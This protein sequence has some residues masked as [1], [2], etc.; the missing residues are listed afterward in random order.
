MIRLKSLLLEKKDKSALQVLFVGD[1]QTLQSNSYAKQLLKK[2]N[3]EGKI[4][5]K[6]NASLSD[7]FIMLQDNMSEQYDVVSILCGDDDSKKEKYEPSIEQLKQ[8]YLF[9]KK[10]DC[11]LVTITTPTKQYSKDPDKYP[12]A[13]A[14]SSWI[15]NQTISDITINLTGLD[16]LDFKKNGILLDSDTNKRVAAEWYSNVVNITS[17]DIESDESEDDTKKIIFSINSEGPDV[18][19]LQINLAALGYLSTTYKRTGNYDD[20]TKSA[21]QQFQRDNGLPDNGEYTVD[22]KDILNK[23]L[24][25]SN[26]DDN[27]KLANLIP[28]PKKHKKINGEIATATDIIDFFKDKGL[29]TEGAAGIA[30]NIS[31]ET[32]GTFSTSILGDN[33]TSIGLAQ[34]HNE[35]WTGPNGFEQWCTRNSLDPWSVE[36]Q[37]E[38][39][40]WELSTKYNSLKTYLESDSITP[41]EAA[42]KFAK[43]FER[44]SSI[45][46][47]RMENAEKFYDE[48]DE[49][50]WIPGL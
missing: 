30:G 22:T 10:F 4:V 49:H 9:V 1:E 44:P 42:F 40:W 12:S 45:S 21:V 34:W 15:E 6:A 18:K 36:G 39:L 17:N 33:G 31:V 27:W 37:L 41:T 13:D 20:A 19:Q 11:V 23:N 38:F 5:A 24:E 32:A 50:P 29:S 35:R 28:K 14:I 25:L 48:Y 8:I 26:Q 43:E 16:N 2:S 46:S 7:I 47:T 3:I